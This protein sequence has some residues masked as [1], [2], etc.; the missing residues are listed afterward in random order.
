MDFYKL[1]LPDFDK[2]IIYINDFIAHQS[3]R[4][5]SSSSLL[6]TQMYTHIQK[7]HLK[8]TVNNYFSK[9]IN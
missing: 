9:F 4:S 1:P 8:D 6:T 5:L 3:I 7:S 2:C